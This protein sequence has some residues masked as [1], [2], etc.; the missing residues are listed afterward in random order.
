MVAVEPGT[1]ADVDAVADRWVALA[2]GQREF[3]S[4]LLADENREQVRDAVAR[5]A[6]AGELAVA[7]AD[8][9]IVGFVTFGVE[10]AH[11]E[12]DTTRGVVQN[13]Y[14]VPEYREEGVGT[15]LLE[16]AESSLVEAGVETVSLEVMADN[17]AARE[18]Y[19]RRGYRPHRIEM[20]KRP[21]S[22]TLTKE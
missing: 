16:T 18:F 11:Y 17:D 10:S 9:E 8:E 12:Q 3:G 19:S 5:R 20:E 22:D 21:E 1:L 14:V 6:V 13:I 7:R 2:E 15:E 4:H